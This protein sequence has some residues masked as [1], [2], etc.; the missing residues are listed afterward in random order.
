M[1]RARRAMLRVA[2][3]LL[4]AGWAAAET[5][6]VVAPDA[7]RLETLAAREIRRYVYLR[8]GALLPV[9]V[10]AEAPAGEAIV[11]ARR[12]R[13]LAAPAKDALDALQPEQYVLK[14]ASVGGAKRLLVCGADDAGTLYAAYSLAERLGVRF[15]LHGDVVPDARVPW[16]IPDLDETGK[17]LFATRGLQPFH[18]F[19]EGPD[20]WDRDDYLSYFAQLPKMRMNFFG[21]HC[22]PEGGVGPE[23]LVWIGSSADLEPSGAVRF[24]YPSQWAST[25]RNGM[26]GYAAM[27]TGDFCAGAA[28]LFAADDFGPE[29]HDGMMPRPKTPEA[30]AELFARSAAMLRDAFAFARALRVKICIGTE[31]PLTI[32]KAVRDRLQQQGKDPKDPAVV[33]DVYTAMFRR[34]QAL[35][36]VDYYW[37]WTPEDWTWGGNK[38][39]QFEATVRDIQAALGALETLGHPFTLGTC[40]W[41]LG[42]QNDRSAL[43]KV[44]PKSCPMSCINRQVGHDPV[45]PGFASVA[46]RPTWA[47]PWMENDPDLVAPQPWAGRMRHDAADAKRYG[48]T[49]LLGIFWRT[50][51]LAANVNALADAAWDLSWVPAGYDMTPVK[52]RPAVRVPGPQGGSVARFSAP[53]D[54]TEE[55]PVYQSVRYGMTGYHYP[56]PNGTYAVTLKFNEPHYGEAGKRVFGVRVQEKPVVQKLDLFAKYGKNKAW[57]RVVN[58]VV[59]KDGWLLIDFVVEVEFPCIAGIVIEGKTDDGKAFVKKVNCGGDAWKDYE[60]DAAVAEAKPGTGKDRSMPVEAFYADFARAWFGDAVGEAAGRILAKTDGVKL[61]EP[62]T[63]K[64]GPGDIKDEK[65]DVAARYA[66][67]GE[68][69]ALRPS[70]KGAGSLERFDY[71]LNTYRYMKAMAEVG[72]ARGRLNDLMKALAGEKDEAKQKEQAQQALPIR[73]ALARAWERMMTFQLAATDTPGE[74]GTIANLEQHNRR[75]QKYV[76][77]HDAALEKALGAALP[78]EARLSTAYAGPARILVPTV[79]THAEPGESLALKVMILTPGAGKDD[80]GAPSGALFWRAMGAGDFAK[81]P[82]RHVARRVYAVQ[83]P[84]APAGAIAIEY[85]IESES[86]G[87]AL[88]WPATAPALCQTVVVSAVR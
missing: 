80:A 49:G 46:G 69:E 76:E 34:I 11:V 61:P 3:A 32:P 17:P 30:S 78:A 38:P 5:P 60:A 87:A 39:E 77:G 10:S 52:P 7:S 84:A 35:H 48:C 47:I 20:W 19:P 57:D 54:G 42:P 83:I 81:V 70:V 86:G 14:T 79:R 4:A 21:L 88:R 8:T 36:P 31:T 41:V 68:L 27:K 72:D 73:L 9:T 45:E 29:T 26:W 40:G 28:A 55:V 1:T 63:W 2:A 18:D 23:P 37:L 16:A 58:G 71:W 25:A 6:V 50:K 62:S 65:I 43:D 82:L 66:F 74:L 24:A 51:I 22:Y 53:V 56:V 13:A 85:Y 44:L 59:V 67:V 12:G 75:H 33:R 64:S 15:Y